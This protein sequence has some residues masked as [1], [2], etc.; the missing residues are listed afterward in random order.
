MWDKK[1]TILYENNKYKK[2]TVNF[3]LDDHEM[4]SEDET[5]IVFSLS[6]NLCLHYCRRLNI[7]FFFSW[8]KLHLF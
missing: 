8:N 4:K 6:L 1:W 5:L 7:S 2:K 3:T